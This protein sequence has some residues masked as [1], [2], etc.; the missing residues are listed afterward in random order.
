MNCNSASLI[1]SSA[2]L[3]NLYGPTE[4]SIDVTAWEC[5][6]DSDR[7]VVPIGRPIANTQ[8]YILDPH[9]NPVPISVVGELHIGGI[10]LA[11]G[12]LNRRELTAKK[13][14]ANPF[15]DQSRSPVI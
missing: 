9:L 4:A 12:Y 7:S 1:A 5:R 10:G 11:R 14:V 2:A 6:R 8:I 15:S 3:H 13:F